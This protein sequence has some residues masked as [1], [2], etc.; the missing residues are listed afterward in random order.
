[1]SRRR[2]PILAP[3][4]AALAIA[5]A[6]SLTACGGGGE[7]TLPAPSME[8]WQGRVNSF[9]S[10]GV[11]ETLALVAPKATRDIPND[12]QARA[13]I[14]DNV[15]NEASPLPRPEGYGTQ[16]ETGSPGST[17]TSSCSARSLA[18]RPTAATT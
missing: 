1:M 10:D 13:E 16:I 6:A 7:D 12:A 18:R 11:Q 9:C 14:L 15:R 3:A 2:H 17:A 5:L 4:I 8:Q